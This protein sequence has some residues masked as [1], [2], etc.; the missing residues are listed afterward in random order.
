MALGMR[1]ETCGAD[2]PSLGSLQMHELRYHPRP[3]SPS[4]PS[5]P[6]DA[7]V[8]RAV[9]AAGGGPAPQPKR[10]GS[11]AGNGR[12]GAIA[13]LALAIVALLSSGAFAATRARPDDAPTLADLQAAAHRAVFTSTDFPV[14]WK[15]DPPDPPDPADD[16]PDANRALAECLGTTYEDSPTEAKSSFSS[17]G[18]TAESEFT[19]ASSVARARADFAALAGPAAPGCF[20]RL[21]RSALDASKPADG[22]YDLRMTPGTL[23]AGLRSGTGPDAVDLRMT[24]TFH[25]NQT[26]VPMTI[27]TISIRHDRIEASL[28]FTS[29]GSAG[30]PADLARSVSDAVVHRL[31]GDNPA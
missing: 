27:E 29:I 7:G 31:A 6:S 15:A 2:V 9:P 5:G 25:R 10:G 16:D 24:V 14:G 21:M 1:C 20:E 28:T 17:A 3:S 26:T 4:A 18:L 30:F 23:A 13:P 19:I 8:A 22:R 11:R 12:S